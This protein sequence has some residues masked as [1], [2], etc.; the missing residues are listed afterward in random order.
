MCKDLWV[1]RNGYMSWGIIVYLVFLDS[2][3]KLGKKLELKWEE[4]LVGILDF[5]VSYIFL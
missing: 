1:E 3:C 2:G 5:D 4:F